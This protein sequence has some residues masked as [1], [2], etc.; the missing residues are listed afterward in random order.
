MGAILAFPLLTPF[1]QVMLIF[2]VMLVLHNWKAL[3]RFPRVVFIVIMSWPA[4]ISSTLLLFPPRLHSPS[5]LPLL[6]SFLV[7]FFPLILPLLLMTVTTTMT[8][9]R[10]GKTDKQSLSSADS[11]PATV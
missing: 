5:Q 10:G 3:P 6:P 4:I 1:N 2:P 9:T 7:S 11:T 8:M